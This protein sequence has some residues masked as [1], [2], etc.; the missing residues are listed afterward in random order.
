MSETP[1]S[2]EFSNRLADEAGFLD[3][4]ESH[5]REI[6]DRLAA[7]HLPDADREVMREIGSVDSEIELRTIVHLAKRSLEQSGRQSNDLGIRL[8]LRRAA[9]RLQEADTEFEKHVKA[10]KAKSSFVVPKKTRPWFKALGQ[11]GQGPA[12]SIADVA[13]AI[14]TLKLPV[15]PETQTWRPIASVTTAIGILLNGVNELR[16]E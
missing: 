2:L 6:A 16:N 15:S 14:G 3:A 7:V 13:L 9:E 4:C 10:K 12:L 11:I 5:A 8:Q 1:Y